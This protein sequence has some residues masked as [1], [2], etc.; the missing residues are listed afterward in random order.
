M[1]IAPQPPPWR[2]ALVVALVALLLGVSAV[3]VAIV[4]DGSEKFTP[5]AH[6]SSTTGIPPTS[7]KASERTEP[8]T[9]TT[10][11]GIPLTT[12]ARPAVEYRVEG[13]VRTGGAELGASTGYDLDRDRGAFPSEGA[14]VLLDCCALHALADGEMS[15]PRGDQPADCLDQPTRQELAVGELGEHPTLCVVT[16]RGALATVHAT[17]VSGPLESGPRVSVTYELW[18]V[19]R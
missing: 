10:A 15:F 7:G 4:L 2:K 19:S 12:T 8:D 11:K 5:P 14:D 16:D 6:D 9:T 17:L 13:P 18:T 1:N 3:V